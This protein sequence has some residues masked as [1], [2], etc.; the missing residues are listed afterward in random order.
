MLSEKKYDDNS[1]LKIAKFYLDKW[2]IASKI[3]LARAQFDPTDKI[4]KQLEI[5]FETRGFRYSPTETLDEYIDTLREN[6]KNFQ[7]K[8]NELFSEQ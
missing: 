1:W 4:L 6:V 7:T 8:L 5:S 3:D 2:D